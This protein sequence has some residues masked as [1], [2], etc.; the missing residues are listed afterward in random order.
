MPALFQAF[1]NGRGTA[2][3]WINEGK[4]TVKWTRLSVPGAARQGKN[5]CTGLAVISI[6]IDGIES[7]R[8]PR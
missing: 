3:Q 4:N 2:E 5:A 1:Y 8:R 7:A 6:V